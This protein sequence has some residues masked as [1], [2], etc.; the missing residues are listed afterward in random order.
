[1]YKASGEL[2]TEDIEIEG[3]KLAFSMTA[4]SFDTASPANPDEY[5]HKPQTVGCIFAADIYA[6]LRLFK[7]RSSAIAGRP[8]DA[9]AC[10]G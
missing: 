6:H 2:H 1:M 3:E 5:R 4:L 8:C 10:Q 7:T 9:K